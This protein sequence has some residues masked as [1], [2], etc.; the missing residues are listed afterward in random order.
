MQDEDD[1][2]R[3]GPDKSTGQSRKGRELDFGFWIFNFGLC[4]EKI[5]EFRGSGIQV[6]RIVLPVHDLFL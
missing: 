3:K 2:S 5:Q 4:S 1:A 6:F